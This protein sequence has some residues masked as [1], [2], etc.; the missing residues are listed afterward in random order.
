MTTLAEI[1][2]AILSLPP[3]KRQQLR[4][5][6]NE[7]EAEISEILS[8]I[9]EGILSMNDIGPAA[10]DKAQKKIA[11]W[12]KQSSGRAPVHKVV[13]ELTDEATSNCHAF[14]KEHGATPLA[15]HQ[16]RA[17]TSDSLATLIN[18][19]AED[20]WLSACSTHV[21]TAIEARRG[22]ITSRLTL[23]ASRQSGDVWLIGTPTEFPL[24]EEY[25]VRRADFERATVQKRYDRLNSIF[26]GQPDGV[27][28]PVL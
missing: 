15:D 8:D 21:F 27:R 11:A 23:H 19:I 26:G 5:W 14:V 18:L 28:P 22:K 3:H 10:F 24:S 17:M 16:A 25:T 7:T 2:E 20:A 13:C 9:D 1:Q 6:L 12:S 4:H